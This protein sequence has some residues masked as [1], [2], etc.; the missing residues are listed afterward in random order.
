MYYVQC[1]TYLHD[2]DGNVL[3]SVSEAVGGLAP[4]KRDLLLNPA[5]ICSKR[6]RNCEQKSPLTK[7]VEIPNEFFGGGRQGMAS[8]CQVQ[9]NN[10]GLIACSAT[11]WYCSP[12][13]F[14]LRCLQ[15]S[16]TSESFLL[17]IH[18]LFARDG[19][20]RRDKA[21]PSKAPRD[22]RPPTDWLAEC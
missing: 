8:A 7:K 18:W 6:S 3:K 2:S 20:G 10:G 1:M 14:L 5:S 12:A 16:S 4:K 17:R 11:K 9:T 19:R 21:A 22:K 15:Q 13:I